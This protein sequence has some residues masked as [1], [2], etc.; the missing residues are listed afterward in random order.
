MIG[1]SELLIEREDLPDDVKEDL[2][3][4]NKEARRTA[5]VA[6]NLLTFSRKQEAQKAPTDINKI[7]QS[8]LDYG[9]INRKSAT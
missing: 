4:I 7:I 5:G 2:K 3:L 8:V 6:R 9:H 1:F